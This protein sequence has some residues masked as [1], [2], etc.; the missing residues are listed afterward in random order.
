MD[1]VDSFWRRSMGLGAVVFTGFTAGLLGIGLGWPFG[2][3][4]GLMLA[5]TLLLFKQVSQAFD[6]CFQFGDAALQRRAAGT[7]GFVHAG[8]IANGAACSCAFQ[9]ILPHRELTR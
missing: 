1:L 5:G 7:S 2:E 4:G 6:M 8:K 3:G 9:K